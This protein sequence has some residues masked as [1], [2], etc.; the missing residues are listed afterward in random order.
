MLYENII[1]DKEICGENKT[2]YK[3]YYLLSIFLN[4]IVNMLFDYIEL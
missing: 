2:R 1:F 3:C 4:Q